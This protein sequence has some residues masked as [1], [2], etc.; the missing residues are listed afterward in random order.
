MRAK[1]VEATATTW[2]A[3]DQDG[4][5]V[6]MKVVDMTDA[7]LFRWIRYFRKKWRD[8][9]FLGPNADIDALIATAIV[10]GPAIFA[11]AVKRGIYTMPTVPGGPV[12]LPTAVPDVPV[13]AGARRITLDE[14]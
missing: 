7:H 4:Q 1:R 2:V 11:E 3:R 6:S 8:E 10:T 9:G 5:M 14:D 13:V 12:T